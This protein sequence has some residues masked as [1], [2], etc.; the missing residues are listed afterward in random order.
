MTS[1]DYISETF[2]KVCQ[3]DVPPITDS[4]N[5]SSGIDEKKSFLKVKIETSVSL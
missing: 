4:L 2:F 3:M 5:N 1:I